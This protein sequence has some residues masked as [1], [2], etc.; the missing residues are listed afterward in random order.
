MDSK[1]RLL[2]GLETGNDVT[3][4]SLTPILFQLSDKNF[5]VAITV[6]KS[7]QSTDFTGNLLLRTKMVYGY[8][9]TFDLHTMI[10]VCMA[11]TKFLSRYLDSGRLLPT[12]ALMGFFAN[13]SVFAL[14]GVGIIKEFRFTRSLL[15]NVC[16]RNN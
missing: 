7:F 2:G 11:E 13:S 8:F 5:C 6:L 16:C 14:F 9:G 10:T 12:L 3:F 15:A 1:I 4:D